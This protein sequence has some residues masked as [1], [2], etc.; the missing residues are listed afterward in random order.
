MKL[1]LLI[2]Q[3]DEKFTQLTTR[4]ENIES[5]QPTPSSDFPADQTK[6]ESS[7]MKRI[8]IA[9]AHDK[10]HVDIP[11]FEITAIHDLPKRKHGRP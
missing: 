5:A 10:L 7:T 6:D 3:K 1:L 4:I 2:K 11:E 9:F 8:F